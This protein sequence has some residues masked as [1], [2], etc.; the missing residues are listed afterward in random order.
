MDF[1]KTLNQEIRCFSVGVHSGRKVGMTIRPAGTDEGI[2]FVRKDIPNSDRISASVHNVTDTTLATTLGAN[3]TKVLTVEHLMSAFNGMGVDNALVEVDTFE[4][5]IMDG[6]AL[7]FVSLLR[8]SGLR[9]QDK[10]KKYLVIRKPISI[11]DGEST[12]MFKP[13]AH[14]EITYKIDFNHPAV[15]QQSY[16][17]VLSNGAYEREICGA[18]TFGFLRD[19][20]Y[21]QA[22]GLALG[23]SLNN[24]IVLDNEKVINKEGLRCPNE[25][26]KHKILDAVG[27][28]YLLGMPIIGHFVAYKSGHKLNVQLLKELLTKEDCWEI[29]SHEDFRKETSKAPSAVVSA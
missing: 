29:L 22:K 17:V 1:Q 9:T 11:S 23:G 14:F 18:R 16:H 3:G 12:A 2:V 13:S 6:S 26:V 7:P 8:E 15:G 5:P 21:L 27:D 19:V 24:A 25:F 28:L 10:T 4:V 20:E